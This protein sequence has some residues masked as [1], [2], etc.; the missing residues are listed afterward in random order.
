MVKTMT[1]YKRMIFA[2]NKPTWQWRAIQ[3]IVV[4][5]ITTAFINIWK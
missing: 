5:W 3:I 2:T 4:L 1:K